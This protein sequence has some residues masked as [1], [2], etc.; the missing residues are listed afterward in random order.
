MSNKQSTVLHNSSSASVRV[1]M[2]H[3]PCLPSLCLIFLVLFMLHDCNMLLISDLKFL[4]SAYV[5]VELQSNVGCLNVG[6]P[7]LDPA[8]V[9][10]LLAPELPSLA[11]TAMACSSAFPASIVACVIACGYLFDQSPYFFLSFATLHE[12]AFFE[13][14]YLMFC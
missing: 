5:S 6:P 2:N 1:S 11:A 12:T 10:S 4:H 13:P 7:N 3:R 14:V 9:A 8:L